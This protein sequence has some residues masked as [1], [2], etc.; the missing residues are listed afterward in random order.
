ML[1]FWMAVSA[2]LRMESISRCGARL[3]HTTE[4]RRLMII[5]ASGSLS[6]DPEIPLQPQPAAVCCT[7]DHI[8]LWPRPVSGQPLGFLLVV[9]RGELRCGI[10]ARTGVLLWISRARRRLL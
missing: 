3:G 10:A 6:A 1:G 2:P 7:L 5:D 4:A 9:E 8:M